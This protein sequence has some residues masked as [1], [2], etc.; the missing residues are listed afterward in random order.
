MLSKEFVNE[1]RKLSEDHIDSSMN[2]WIG[3]W[4]DPPKAI[5]ILRVLDYCIFSSLASGFVVLILDLLYTEA[6]EA[7]GLTNDQVSEFAVWRD[8]M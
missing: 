1:L 4:S 3:E 7:E 6:L 5:E 8:K 2:Q